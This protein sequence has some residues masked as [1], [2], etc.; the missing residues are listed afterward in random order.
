LN[1]RAIATAKRILQQE[2]KAAKWVAR[3]ALRELTDE[4]TLSR[5]K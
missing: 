5:L 1:K 4:K 2:S 3:D